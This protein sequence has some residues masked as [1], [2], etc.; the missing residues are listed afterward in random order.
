VE[1]FIQVLQ[2][3][4]LLLVAILVFLIITA[5]SPT[6]RL[7]VDEILGATMSVA[8]GRIEPG[9][10]HLDTVLRIQPGL[11]QAA[12]A[13]A[14]LALEAG[15]PMRARVYLQQIPFNP[16]YLGRTT[17]LAARADLIGLARPGLT[18]VELLERCPE[19]HIELAV[20]AA[21][22]ASQESP[23]DL[24]PVLEALQRAG[25]PDSNLDT[26]LAFLQ[27]VSDPL[28]AEPLLRAQV[29]SG[30]SS[31]PLALDQLT[32]IRDASMEGSQ[33]FI[34]AQVGQV[35]A[36]YQEWTLAARA[37]QAALSE[38]ESY[39]EAR[40]YLGLT[41]EMLGKDGR[42]ELEQ[43]VSAAPNAALPHAFLAQHWKLIGELDRAIREQEIAARL[44]PENPAIAAELGALYA[45]TG[46]H[47]LAIQAYQVATRLAPLD[48]RF[49]RL[50]AEYS[51]L[52]ETQPEELAI[53]AARNAFVLE[54][55]PPDA[56]ALLGY[57]HLLTGDLI[58]SQRL[59]TQAIN[60]TPYNVFNQFA[61]GMLQ[62]HQ[63]DALAGLATMRMAAQMK[64]A[65]SIGEY[66]RRSA[67]NML[68]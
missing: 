5:P 24:A 1:R 4:W 19:A 48:A 6:P 61:Y 3:R 58:L 53:P 32:A 39:I 14:D 22:L 33:A 30:N 28:S 65:D 26:R 16:K 12:L 13:A 2:R 57:A 36:R 21:N 68:R 38:D 7:L 54:A 15:D 17:C 20:Y 18:W 43:A 55:E 59:I 23:E 67:E 40:A 49:W 41:Y 52:Y 34:F 10:E 42:S 45:Q 51:I 31:A 37:F 25:Y 11:D 44:E 62:I 47:E 27:T 66:A 46:A 29:Q 8:A 9:L 63:G 56:N 35:F 64:P 60:R 50:L